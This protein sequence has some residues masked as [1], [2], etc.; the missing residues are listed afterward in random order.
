MRDLIE[1]LEKATGPDR[2]VDVAIWAALFADP[3][4]YRRASD[5]G[6]RYSDWES[7]HSG[8]WEPFYPILNAAPYTASID[9]AM[10]L[11]PEGSTWE[12]GFSDNRV[13]WAGIDEH[14]SYRGATAAIALCIA[15]LKAR[16]TALSKG[17]S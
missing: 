13:F 16:E 8:K 11:V 15:A 2:D 1:R 9:A 14:P 10:M 6:P 17:K 12:V 4:K 3:R 7:N 5:E